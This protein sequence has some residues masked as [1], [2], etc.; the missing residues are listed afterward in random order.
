MNDLGEANAIILRA[1]KIEQ[2]VERLLSH[3]C[4]TETEIGEDISDCSQ[5]LG[6]AMNAIMNKRIMLISDKARYKVIKPFFQA[7]DL[8]YAQSDKSKPSW[9]HGEVISYNE[10]KDMD[11]YGP[12]RTYTI[13]FDG[14]EKVDVKD[15]Q[16]IKDKEYIL[17]K[18][19]KESDWKGVKRVVDKDST[20]PWARE[21]GWYVTITIDEELGE[22]FT[23]LSDALR[24]HDMHAVFMKREE[25]VE[26]RDLNFPREYSDLLQ[27]E[28]DNHFSSRIGL[29]LANDRLSDP[30]MRR[31]GRILI[32]FI[33]PS[34]IWELE[35]P[36]R[37]W[38][39]VT[40]HIQDGEWITNREIAD[41]VYK[42]A[43]A[44]QCFDPDSVSMCTYFQLLIS[45]ITNM[46]YLI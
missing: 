5:R 3:I 45:L 46:N 34:R 42:L 19:I 38:K 23:H 25:R 21:V 16:L 15:Y 31:I 24:A 13:L 37:T 35:D 11:G 41:Y 30:I 8:V 20:D 28:I 9:E 43:L 27:Y 44:K 39:L 29:M 17:S 18:G 33:H 12:S 40:G 26:N 6:G 2:Q 7:G 4:R 1:I 10:Y 14:G 22:P 32:T 36:D